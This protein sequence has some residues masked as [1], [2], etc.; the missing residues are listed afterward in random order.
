MFPAFLARLWLDNDFPIDLINS[1]IDKSKFWQIRK[2]ELSDGM[3]TQEEYAEW[4]LN[5]P[6]ICGNTPKHKW[7]KD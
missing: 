4:K 6:D 3:I 1:E 7:R 2:Q 5:W